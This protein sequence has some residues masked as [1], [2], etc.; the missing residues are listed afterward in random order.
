MA[1]VTSVSHKPVCV[2]YF[3]FRVTQV[4]VYTGHI[5]NF[6]A[7]DLKTDDNLLLMKIDMGAGHG[8]ASG[9]WEP[10]KEIALDYA[11]IL[12]VFNRL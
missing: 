7:S 1:C 8:G 10:L 9:R 3:A 2:T 6:D 12:K 5:C 11:F 4:K